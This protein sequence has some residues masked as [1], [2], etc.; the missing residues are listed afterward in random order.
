MVSLTAE[1]KI[2]IQL[3]YDYGRAAIYFIAVGVELLLCLYCL[4]IHLET[5]RRLRKGRTRYIYLLFFMG[6]MYIAS[7]AAGYY[8][9]YSMYLTSRPDSPKAKAQ[10]QTSLNGKPAWY[11]YITLVCSNSITWVGDGL[12]VF[13]CF[14]VWRE[15]PWVTLL[16]ALTYLAAVALSIV[17]IIAP[18]SLTLQLGK[19]YSAWIILTVLVNVFVTLLIAFR[20]LRLRNY[21]SKA[22]SHSQSQ[23][24]PSSR[25]ES[26]WSKGKNWDPYLGVIAI[27][28]E[29]AMPLSLI[30]IPLAALNFVDTL[31]ASIASGVLNRLF[32]AFTALAPQMII[33][34][35]TI[36]KSW[37][38]RVEEKTSAS[39]SAIRS[40]LAFDRRGG[41]ERKGMVHHDATFDS[42]TTMERRNSA[43]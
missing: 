39:S 13:R 22:F 25:T 8:P 26:N 24:Y 30:G 41:S 38:N 42:D 29:S 11:E 15:N 35:V 2:Y 21:L 19:I 7:E 9:F 43:S 16:P 40:P 5:P 6:V 20:L 31:P 18:A 3:Q 27:I 34:R 32:T 28:V 14:I 12:L 17:L 36:G 1:D 4:S 23:S 37:V 10:A 33:F